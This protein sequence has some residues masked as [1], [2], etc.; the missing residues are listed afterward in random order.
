MLSDA[1]PLV[2]RE[3]LRELRSRYPGNTVVEKLE[4]TIIREHWPRLQEDDLR[5]VFALRYL[6]KDDI[7]QDLIQIIATHPAFERLVSKAYDPFAKITAPLD[8]DP[9][10]DGEDEY[11]DDYTDQSGSHSR[12]PLYTKDT[13]FQIIDWKPPLW[14]I[15]EK[16]DLDRIAKYVPAAPEPMKFHNGRFKR[17]KR[18]FSAAAA[19]IQFLERLTPQKR[20]QVRKIV[21]Q[22]NYTGLRLS[23]T[24]ARGLAPYLLENPRLRIERRVNSWGTALVRNDERPYGIEYCLADVVAWIHEASMPWIMDLPTGSFSLVL[25]GPTEEASQLLC[26][27]IIRAAIWQDGAE[28]LKLRTA[29]IVDDFVDIIKAVVRGDVP[30]RFEAD[31]HEL[32]DIDK[33]LR[34]HSG[35]WPCAVENRISF[36][37]FDMPYAGWDAVRSEYMEEFVWTDRLDGWDLMV[38]RCQLADED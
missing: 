38:E 9:P 10:T 5:H 4:K 11:E 22:E 17:F 34:E 12:Q 29:P 31:M 23:Q 35:R 27:A 26:N 2:T 25:H 33:I 19:A 6:V 28:K 16:G 32:W 21:I 14:W 7:L 20:A 15:P 13:L 8:C 36:L 18:Y 3:V 24:H 37:H 1:Y 30:V